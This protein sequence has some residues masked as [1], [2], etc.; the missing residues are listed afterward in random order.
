V[1]KKK[2][3]LF[4]GRF[5]PFH[6]GHLAAVRYALKRVDYLYI[7]VGSAQ[8][9]HER[10]NPFTAGERIMMI[11][12]ALDE[13][14]VDPSRWMLIPVQDAE[15]HSVWTATLK[16]TVPKFDIV[17][18][19]DT[20]TIRLLKEEG[21]EVVPIPYLDRDQ[22]SATNVRNRILERKD[23]EKL[24]PPAIARMVMELD[25]VDRVRS[26]I[27]KDTEAS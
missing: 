5:Q 24:V 7:V 1:P 8:R 17:F 27:N 25:G 20:L 9:S 15:S 14:K 22:Y 13:A 18:S 12:A 16:S 6:N 2:V 21:I 11:K 19:N 3:G 26:M 23:W 10:Y 4:V